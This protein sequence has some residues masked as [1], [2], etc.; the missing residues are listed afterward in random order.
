F[1]LQQ[2]RSLRAQGMGPDALVLAEPA[3][4]GFQEDKPVFER[5]G[6]VSDWRSQSA[7]AAELDQHLARPCIPG[8][9]AGTPAIEESTDRGWLLGAAEGDP[10]VCPGTPASAGRPFGLLDL[11]HRDPARLWTERHL[12]AVEDGLG[13]PVCQAQ[14]D[15]PDGIEARGGETGAVL[16]S[17][18]RSE[19]RRVGKVSTSGW[20]LT[21]SKKYPR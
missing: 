15:L 21:Y 11:T 18:Y 2:V 10:W 13:A 7:A 12:Q 17:A 1:S 9:L 14:F 5:S 19:E 16:R 8:V 4:P 20:P 3:A 6:R